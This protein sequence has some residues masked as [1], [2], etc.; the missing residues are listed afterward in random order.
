MWP[1]HVNRKFERRTLSHRPVYFTPNSF[2][3]KS[4]MDPIFTSSTNTVED[5]SVLRVDAPLV[6]WSNSTTT[7][8][9]TKMPTVDE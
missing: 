2:S 8:S 4:N 1:L 3:G 5:M 6:A 7:R 9:P